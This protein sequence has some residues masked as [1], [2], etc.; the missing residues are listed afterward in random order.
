MAWFVVSEGASVLPASSPVAS[1]LTVVNPAVCV[2][3]T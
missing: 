3:P 2:V 1:A